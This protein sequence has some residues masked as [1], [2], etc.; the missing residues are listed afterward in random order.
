LRTVRALFE[1]RISKPEIKRGSPQ[2][3]QID[4]DD[5]IEQFICVYLR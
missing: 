1:I 2:I 4:A 3:T 5:N